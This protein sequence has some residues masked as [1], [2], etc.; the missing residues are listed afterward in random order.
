MQALTQ[1]LRYAGRMLCRTPG[2]TAVVVLL[3]GIGIGATTA[4]FSVLNVVVLRNLPVRDPHQLVELLGQF[5]GD[6]RMNGFGWQ[7]FE[8]YRDHNHVFSDL[9]GIGPATFRVTGGSVDEP[10]VAGEYVAGDFFP[11]LGLQPAIGRLIGA[12]DNRA[13]SDPAVAVVSWSYWQT[14]FNRDPSIL[15]KTIVLDGVAARVIGVAPRGFFGLRVG[16]SPDLWVPAAMEPMIPRPGR[17]PGEARSGPMLGLMG[18]LKPGVTIEQARAEMRVLDR[19]RVEEIATAS[20]NPQWRNATIHVEPAGGG[21]SQLRDALATPVLTLTAIAALLLLLTCTNVAS[22]MLARAA[23]RRR[24]MATRVALGADRVR[25][26]RQVLTE[27]LLLSTA[28]SLLGV[29]VAYRG[30]D[31][32]LRAWPFDSRMLAT[33]RFEIFT[34]GLALLTGILFGLAPAWHAFSPATSSSLRES[35]VAAETKGRRLFGQSL[36]VAQVALSLVLLSAAAVFARHVSSLKWDLGFQRDS[37]LLVTLDPSRSGYEREQL[38]RLY[39]DLLER[40]QR[41]PGVRSA[42]LSALTPIARGGASRF[43]TVEGFDE[44]PEDRRYL[45]LNWVAPKYFETTGTP[46]VAGR[47]FE[48]AD[49]GRPRVAIVNRAMARHYFGG[50]TAIGRRLSFDGQAQKYEIVGVAG[51]A[52]YDDIRAA[53]PRM[54]YLHAFQEA[55]GSFSQ[56]A[57]RTDGRPTRVVDQVRSAVHD[58]LKTVPVAKVTTLADQVDAAIVA[59]RLIAKLSGIFGGLGAVLAALGLYGLLAYTVA[60]RT[61][62]IGI[63]MALGATG[64]D[65]TRM[66]L[67]GALRLVCAGLVLGVPIAVWSQRFAAARIENLRVDTALTIAVAAVSMVSVALLAAYVPARRAA[68]VHPMEALRHS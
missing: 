65:V 31:A 12:Q 64:R 35:G 51:D 29:F 54:V 47:D 40:L 66:V 27:S 5:P 34:A 55:R 32:L 7:V 21:F 63:R 6:P 48:S 10:T 42:T 30:A 57:L 59:E 44:R 1:D 25:L 68:R 49:E 45:S 16:F 17:R 62:E 46:I 56:F 3:L 33:A 52:K 50:G 58:V 39:Q 15:N 13:G 2:F 41:I 23:S 43:A 28:G 37:V 61:T 36:I 22:M 53:P 38:A 4:M 60:R 26:V 20:R 24:E 9:I 11:A 14:R 19:A 18:R 67:T 8:H